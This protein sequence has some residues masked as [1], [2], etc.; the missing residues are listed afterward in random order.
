MSLTLSD[1]AAAELVT[2][3]VYP[4]TARIDA[5]LAEN[6]QLPTPVLVVDLDIVRERY[7]RLRRALPSAEVFYAVKANPDAAVVGLLAGLGSNFDVASLGE[8][9]LCLGLGIAPDRLS[10]G[11]TVKKEADVAAAYARG[12][13][14]FA[15][16][17]AVELAKIVRQAP[18][19]TVTVRLA[20]DGDGADWPLSRKFG[21]STDEVAEQL[22]AAAEAGLDLGVSF[23]VGSQQRDPRAWEAP[24]CAVAALSDLLAARGHR[25]SAVNLGGGLPSTHFHSTGPVEVYGVAIDAAL[26]AYLGT[27]HGLRTMVEPGRYLV[28]DAGLIRSEVVLSTPKQTDGGRRWVY[29]D[30]GMFNGLVETQEEA[31][32]YRMRCPGTRGPLEPAVV[33]GP[34]CDSLDVLYEREPYP[35]PVDLQVGGHVDLLSTGAYTTTYSSVWF[36]GFEPL[37]AHYLPVSD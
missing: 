28:G 23:H 16:D 35:L 24:L 37:Q 36:N 18:G 29:L 4:S 20:S 17:S 21:A 13:R 10:Y 34:T 11:N 14:I 8:I 25:L 27:D 26:E 15:V 22:L 1:T 12:V 32:R 5:F 31:I 6:P 19:S 9:D 33:A 3:S 7:L 2:G 30:I